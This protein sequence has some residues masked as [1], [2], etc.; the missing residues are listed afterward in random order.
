VQRY[1]TMT[2]FTGGQVSFSRE[3]AGI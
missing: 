3:W 1:D 2:L